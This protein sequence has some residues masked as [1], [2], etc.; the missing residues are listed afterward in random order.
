MDFFFASGFGKSENCYDIFSWYRRKRLCAAGHG[1]AEGRR[2][3]VGFYPKFGKF[4]WI[5][6]VWSNIFRQM[7]KKCGEK[8]YKIVE[9]YLPI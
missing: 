2:R 5:I 9:K 8:M 4:C 7:M 3:G 6:L 1:D